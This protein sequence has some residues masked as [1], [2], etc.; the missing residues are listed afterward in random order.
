MNTTDPM[1][2]TPA[3]QGP[4]DTGA[5]KSARGGAGHTDF[6][7]FHRFLD[8]VHCGLCIPSC[9]TFLE[10]GTEMDSPRGRIQLM[11]S[12]HEGRLGLDDK[13]VLH[14]DGC[15]GCRACETACPSG[16]RY[17]ELIEGARGLIQAHYPRSLR[18]RVKRWAINRVFPSPWAMRQFSRLTSIM[19]FLRL[20][21][22]RRSS[23]LPSG[24]RQ[25]LRYLPDSRSV[26][27]KVRIPPDVPANG[28]RRFRVGLLSGCIM[29]NLF[30]ATHAN[31]VKLLSQNGCDIHLPA[32]AG[33]CGALLLHNGEKQRGLTLARSVIKAFQAR[34][35]DAIL[36]NAAG[37]GAAMKEYGEHF[38]DDPELRDAALSVSAKVKDITE[39]L[40]EVPGIDP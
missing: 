39:F 29:P 20:H 8:C 16:V 5:S 2:T 32:E 26:F 34:D 40:A 23:W 28:T 1:N 37:C 7:E 30:G 4:F 12:I 25:I 36:T 33:C 24:L 14:L 9:P 38:K 11:R 19:M 17:G 22:L 3:R 35:L 15:L 10:L 27:S 6:V 31:T 21:H 13:S 18:E